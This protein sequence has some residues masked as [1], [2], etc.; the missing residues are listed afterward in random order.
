MANDNSS[1]FDENYFDLLPGENKIVEFNSS[2]SLEQVKSNLQVISLYDS[3]KQ[4][5]STTDKEHK[6]KQN[7]FDK[8]SGLFKKKSEKEASSDKPVV[9]EK[10]EVKP[11]QK[12]ETVKEKDTTK[13]GGEEKKKSIFDKASGLFKKK[14]TGSSSTPSN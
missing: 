2:L 4:K 8:A 10:K 13:K 6:D 7:I 9:P 12:T 14:D 3:F 11:V 5:E 1:A